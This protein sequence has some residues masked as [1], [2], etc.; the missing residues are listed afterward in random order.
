MPS[1][2]SDSPE[3]LRSDDRLLFGPFELHASQR[4][5]QRD[6]LA[7]IL[8]S[9]AMDILLALLE[10]PGAILSQR[11]LIARVWP[12]TIVEDVNL[13]V[14][15]SALRRALRDGEAGR[16]VVTVPGR[17]YRFVHP[18]RVD[19]P[20]G[21]AA[22]P[23]V[24][25]ATPV[26][27]AP[28]RVIGRDATIEQIRAALSRGRL[29][30]IIGPGGIGKTAVAA[31]VADIMRPG[32]P[33]GVHWVDLAAITPGDSIAAAIALATGL[34][35]FNADPTQGLIAW[36]QQKR[37]LLVLDSCE[38]VVGSTAALAERILREAPGVLVLTTSREALRVSGE[39]VIRLAPLPAP[40]PDGRTLTAAEAVT[41]PAVAL[42]AERATAVLD[43]FVLRD[44]DVPAV[45]GICARLD[46]IALAIELAAGH[47]VAFELATLAALLDDKFRLLAAGR[48]TALPR[49]R[50]MH[51]ALEWSYDVLP[52]AE[53]RILRRLAPFRSSFDLVAVRAVAA[54][55]E[56]G[57]DDLAEGLAR[58]TDKSL[59]TA[60]IAATGIS[61]R[62]LDTTR[63]FA[64]ARLEASGE[65]REMSRRHAEHLG[66]ELDRLE[67]GGFELSAADWL[68]T[69]RQLLGDLRAALDWAFSAGGSTADA[70]AI[71]ARAVRLFFQ[72]SLVEECRRRAMQ[73]LDAMAS[74]AS[75]DSRLEMRLRTDLAHASLY[76][77]GPMLQA[78]AHWESVL[79]IAT[80]LQAVE[81]QATAL[82]GLLSISIHRNEPV[83]GLAYAERFRDLRGE[84]PAATR[85]LL[86]D[87][88]IG[89]AHHLKGDQRAARAR[90]EAMV[91]RYDPAMHGWGQL[92]FRVDH[93]LMA[94]TTLARI[95]WLQGEPDRALRLCAECVAALRA[96]DHAI[97]LCYALFEVAIPLHCWVGDLAGA[98]AAWATLRDA[99][100]RHGLAIFQAGAA[101]AVLAIDALRGE[102]DAPAARATFDTLRDCG[103]AALSPWLSGAMA[104]ASIR[105]GDAAGGLEWIEPELATCERSGSLWWMAELLRLRGELAA[106]AAGGAA[107]EAAAPYL[108]QASDLAR[109]Q[110]ALALELR[111]AMSAVRL[112]AD[113]DRGS[114]RELDRVRRCFR[115]GSGTQDLAAA[116]RML[117]GFAS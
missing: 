17:G 71:T 41:Y 106:L 81:Y 93:A 26:P 3:P 99:A 58:L 14:H 46:G 49:H 69:R 66:A 97:T 77:P 63:A 115:E 65:S 73:A 95:L 34:A 48:R 43:R 10:R 47:L 96:Q 37:M 59:I 72:L 8:G 51:A 98:R 76:T 60:G 84:L 29:V 83:Q 27:L 32:C 70:I 117:A 111:A 80:G 109:S 90:L 6:G 113:G 75:G 92:G 52:E 108:R 112:A 61:Y 64:L 7:I 24:P 54:D 2:G 5:L 36:L 91:A 39:R 102:I 107:F 11:D 94:R 88:M 104:A 33:D 16:Y 45:V 100:D 9:R 1:D 40:P 57:A 78:V 101:C 85:T 19:R 31:S 38:R 22:D 89:L 12:G 67:A 18:L 82:W 103:Y 56:L 15:V 35:N 114:R 42:F 116:E 28:A 110:H 74:T 23:P 50:T 87:R 68:A 30:S 62:L 44:A 4:L 53:R 55:A 21:S 25:P 105:R 79:T 20:S 86:G 13:R